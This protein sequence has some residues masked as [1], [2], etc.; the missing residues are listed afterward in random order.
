[1][2]NSAGCDVTEV[3]HVPL[4][5]LRTIYYSVDQRERWCSSL[6]SSSRPQISVPALS[7]CHFPKMWVSLVNTLN[8]RPKEHIMA[9]CSVGN[10][11]RLK[12]LGL[13]K[14]CQTVF[15]LC[16]TLAF[17]LFGCRDNTLAELPTKLNLLPHSKKNNWE[18]NCPPI[19]DDRALFWAVLNVATTRFFTSNSTRHSTAG[20]TRHNQSLNKH[21][22]QEKW[23]N[24]ASL[25]VRLH[26]H[27]I[28]YVL[29]QVL[30]T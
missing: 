10:R 11:L 21:L 29:V 18:M 8:P 23:G 13:G 2:V 28:I 25:Q 16:T 27:I 30:V 9:S 20:K 19:R 12:G 7:F 1:M 17:E 3:G 15:H 6:W 14:A 4:G 26:V 5:W 22:W 24:Q